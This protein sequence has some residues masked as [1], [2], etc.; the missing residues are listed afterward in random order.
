MQIEC[1]EEDEAM[2]T[3]LVRN[4]PDDVYRE[5]EARAALAGQSLSEYVVK[6]LERTVQRPTTDELVERVRTLGPSGVDE[7]GADAVRAERRTGG[8]ASDSAR[9][10]GK[11][12][13][14]KGAE[15]A[16]SRAG[17]TEHDAANGEQD[18]AGS[19]QDA[20]EAGGGDEHG[21]E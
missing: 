10:A 2:N 12:A 21:D 5:L 17:R 15:P 14:R 20:A 4:V 1:S 18:V 9:M 3:I 16:G 7:S 6:E 8:G 11:G 19:E 13:E